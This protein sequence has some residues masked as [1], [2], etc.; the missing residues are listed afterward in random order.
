MHFRRQYPVLHFLSSMF[1]FTGNSKGGQISL[2]KF[3]HLPKFCKY[4]ER[5]KC[6]KQRENQSVKSVFISA[7][8][9]IDFQKIRKGEPYRV[10]PDQL[11]IHIFKGKR[12]TCGCTVN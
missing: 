3:F 11:V 2:A 5:I 1:K 7:L 9:K 6:L 12:F 8:R 10:V 4:G